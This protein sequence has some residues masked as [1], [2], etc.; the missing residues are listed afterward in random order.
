MIILLVTS[1][2]LIITEGSR[3]ILPAVHALTGSNLVGINCALGTVDPTTGVVQS[4]RDGNGT[5]ENICQWA[6]DTDLDG[7]TIEAG[8]EP[9]VTDP[10]AANPSTPCANSTISTPCGAPGGGGFEADIIIANLNDYITGFDLTLFYNVHVLNAV[11]IDQAGLEFGANVGC[12]SCTFTLARTIDNTNGAV[13]LAQTL[14]GVAAGSC[15]PP[16]FTVCATLTL[17]RVRFVVV[18]AGESDLTI[19]G[20]DVVNH[21]VGGIAGALLPHTDIPGRFSTD[22]FYNL[23]VNG[24]PSSSSC[25]SSG[26]GFN[27]SW[28]YSPN[29]EVPGSP[30]TFTA[31][32]ACQ[33]CTGALSYSW[34]WNTTE[35]VPPTV[36]A[37]GSSV[38]V[39]S[40]FPKI[41]RVTLIVRDSATPVPNNVTATRVLPL[42]GAIHG[43]STISTGESSGWNGWWNGGISPYAPVQLKLCPPSGTSPVKICTTPTIN[44]AL[45]TSPTQL[46]NG[47]VSGIAYNFAGLYKPILSVTDSSPQWVTTGPGITF[48]TITPSITANFPLN[49]TGSN[50]A[51]AVSVSSNTTATDVNRGVSLSASVTYNSTY[52]SS[53]RATS[54]NYTF[55]FGDGFSLSSLGGLSGPSQAITHAYA[56]TGTYTILVTAQESSST[57]AVTS[58]TE[59]AYSSVAVASPPTVSFSFAP[60]GLTAGQ[61]VAFTATVS[62][63]TSPYTYSWNFGDGTTGTGS[64]PAHTYTSAGSYNVTL[65]VTDSGGDVVVYSQ[66]IDVAAVQSQP[67]PLYGY[68][69]IGAAI[70]AIATAATLLFMRRR[71]GSSKLP[72]P[73]TT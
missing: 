49:V 39:T 8:A 48:T 52:P 36:Q 3:P 29:P 70:A 73:A 57:R 22:T 10:A 1:T 21:N 34:A 18:G 65:A 43:P 71:R 67:L 19:G 13:R 64:S 7:P 6:G 62:A 14:V 61:S 45:S 2:V 63:G 27:A 17:F 23:I 72:N 42:S 32:A 55:H 16:D 69:G 40:P 5:I 35:S 68:V 59:T 54:F 41:T 26:L 4:G 15:A 60:A 31:T 58:I 37:T 9:L 46:Q 25:T 11:L 28:T 44:F 47:T 56:V 66:I 24:C 50:P 12:S 20:L 33:N 30:I 51:F 53:A 38:T